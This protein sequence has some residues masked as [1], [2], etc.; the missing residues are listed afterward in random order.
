MNISM[1]V[2]QCWVFTLYRISSVPLTAV[3]C[4]TRVFSINLENPSVGRA[5]GKRYKIMS[6][7]TTVLQEIKWFPFT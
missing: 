1:R 7:A 3:F 4:N 5:G 2:N 6:K